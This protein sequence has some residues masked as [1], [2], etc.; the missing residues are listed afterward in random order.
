MKPVQIKSNPNPNI[1]MN[2]FATMNALPTQVPGPVYPMDQQMLSMM[3]AMM[4]AGL[5]PNGK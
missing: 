4:A 1:P 5:M 3:T 2:Q